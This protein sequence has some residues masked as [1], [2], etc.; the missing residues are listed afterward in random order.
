MLASC[1]SEPNHVTFIDAGE[2][3]SEGKYAEALSK[4]E[5]SRNDEASAYNRKNDISFMLDRGLLA[6]YAGD[7][8]ASSKDLQ[9][10]ERLI[11]EA[12]TQDISDNFARYMQK[13]PYTVEY[14]GEDF[15][16]IYI[17]VFCAL[18]YYHEGDL[19]NA[20]VEIIR[21]NE[22]LPYIDDSYEA[23]K[24]RL[25]EQFKD[26][27]FGEAAHYTKSALARYLGLLF[28]RGVGRPDDA[29]IDA[30][31]ITAAF[32]AAPG[33]YTNRLPAELVMRDE[34]CDELEIPRGMARLNILSFTGLSPYKIALNP[35]GIFHTYSMG[36]PGSKLAQGFTQTPLK[37]LSFRRSAVSRI[38]IVF[39]GGKKMNLSLLEPI[40][41]VMQQV[42]ETRE[43]R[44]RQIL[45]LYNFTTEMGSGIS[46]FFEIFASV[47][48][49]NDRKKEA[50]R[51]RIENENMALDLRMTRFLPGAAYVGGINLSPGEYSFTV[52]Y[53]NEKTVIHSARY[54]KIRVESGKLNLLED[55]Y[56]DYT[57]S[58]PPISLK[59][60][61]G[62]YHADR[63]FNLSS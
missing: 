49:S 45:D 54:E 2:F 14:G 35:N 24:A 29:R 58:R 13:N 63:G 62:N 37:S 57:E 10:C 42:Y 7:Y 60:V 55:F 40:G 61:E 36:M 43:D 16:N 4:V 48:W 47:F 52:N 9:E 20:I 27:W 26:F 34:A 17:N 44:S 11:E 8:A 22:K 38:E 31:E 1:A 23:Q 59:P 46:D 25:S 30:Q 3:V 28:W 51:E 12:F 32:A 39:D 33:I 19:E 21:M 53:Y 18:N 41:N 56:F 6:Y 50:I 5:T 15:E